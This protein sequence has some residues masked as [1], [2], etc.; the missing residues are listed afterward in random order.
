MNDL[1]LDFE[2]RSAADIEKTGTVEYLLHPTTEIMAL[3]YAVGDEPV[4]QVRREEFASRRPSAKFLDAIRRLE[5]HNTLFEYCGWNYILAK[6][7]GWPAI[8]DPKR[9]S[10]TM[11][12]AAMCN[13]PL[14]LDKLSSALDLPIKKDLE[15][16]KVMLSLSRPVGF[17]PAGHPIYNEDRDAY[18]RMYAYNRNDVETER[19]VSK[20]LP[21]LS[22]DERKVWE[23]D[24]KINLRGVRIDT[25]L[26]RAAKSLA[27]HFT[28]KLNEPLKSMTG[29]FI[30]KASQVAVLIEWLEA[31]GV[32][33]PTKLDKDKDG[34]PIRKK[35][36]DKI[37]LA[38]VLLR[39]DL[40]PVVRE[41]LEI[42]REVGKSST[43]KYRAVVDAASPR[44]QR[45]RG[46]L[47][48]HAAGT[49]RWGGRLFQPQN[50]P[51][52]TLPPEEVEPA[53]EAI[54]ENNPTLL[55]MMYPRPMEALSSC[56]RGCLIPAPGMKFLSGDYSSIE[57]RKVFWLAGD[58]AALAKYR[59]GVDLYIDM[60]AFVYKRDPSTIGKKS[61]ERQ[62]GK[63]IIL[64]CGYGMG[65]V[66]FR[67]SCMTDQF[68]PFDPGE[69]LARMAVTSYRKKYKTVRDEWY[70]VEDAA[71]WAVQ[72]PGKV[73][74]CCAG[75]V[76]YGMS[77]DRRFL[78]C[79]LPSGRPLRYYKPCVKVEETKVGVKP[80]LYFYGEHPE[81]KQWVLLSTYGG[82]LFENITQGDARD[83]MAH[84]MLECEATQCPVVLHTHDELLAEVPDRP[85]YD[86]DYLLSRM[87]KLP[88]WCADFPVA[89][90]GWEGYRYRK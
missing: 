75:K 9:W 69:E 32:E 12:R 47:Q 48:Y 33:V 24:L 28:D 50:L 49:G 89:S 6:K 13:M 90:E 39:K 71:V 87:M 61:H 44:D 51:Q 56:I 25:T 81:T 21:D 72:N 85:E 14:G 15:G 41:V 76:F 59:A 36:L 2:T 35:S 65:H 66:R 1:I 19:L 8:Y 17:T 64:G 40:P 67:N 77:P 88:Y 60:A 37:G 70:R 55:E 18:E 10:D 53:I 78:V 83:V 80:V 7:L 5:A 73:Y 34:K 16:R 52:G 42:R 54:K 57:A 29:G 4:C 43:S 23:L 38:E 3:A 20:A 58:Q 45:L 68:Y 86:E 31:R 74:S 82:A 84:G 27:A 30:D 22:D 11:A 63:K 46:S 26:A 62:L 79:R